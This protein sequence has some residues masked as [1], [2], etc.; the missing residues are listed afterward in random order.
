MARFKDF[1]KVRLTG[2]HVQSA[3]NS[4]LLSNTGC[5]FMQCSQNNPC[6][7]GTCNNGYCCTSSIGTGLTNQP[8]ITP[9]LQHQQSLFTNQFSLPV[10]V[11]VMQPAYNPIALSGCANGGAAVGA[12]INMRCARGYVC[13]MGNIC[14]PSTDYATVTSS[15]AN[16][17]KN[18]FLCT[19]GTQAAGACILG[20]CGSSFSCVNGLCCNVTN[21]TPRCL[22]GSPSVGACLLGQCGAG[23]VCTTG[24]LCCKLTSS[25]FNVVAGTCPNGATSIGA[26]ING[27]CP[28]SY[29]CIN[30][31]CCP[32]DSNGAFRCSNP[33]YALGPCVGNQCPDGG[34]QCDTSTNTCCPA[35]DPVGPCIEPGDQ[36][37]TGHICFKEGATPLCFKECNG[38]GTASGPPLSGE[39]PDGTT[40]IFGV[41][42]TS[43]TRLYD[44][45]SASLISG[46]SSDYYL[47]PI[48][49]GIGSC[50]DGTGAISACI[51][52][53]CGYGYQCYSNI[54]CSPQY[55]NTIIPFSR[56]SLRPIGGQCELT[57]QCMSSMEGLSIC[58][59]G[60]CRCLPGAY[61]HGFTCV[62]RFINNVNEMIADVLLNDAGRTFINGTSSNDSDIITSGS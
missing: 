28:T 21:N 62:S 8:H 6:Y 36:C 60:I 23:F 55:T 50:P 1:A 53:Q 19:D 32:Q 31:Q 35:V 20:Q 13:S 26:C 33:N 3:G 10:P 61:V 27:L 16:P 4:H 42:C 40:L 38:R 15:T 44:S 51:N 22:D 58:E 5:T 49:S 34:Y 37:P 12:C 47:S 48:S 41:C 45:I 57:Q 52:G 2:Y 43:R 9:S 39:C 17:L 25:M 11:N 18:P 59:L 54:C 56:A 46:R 14:C 7:R 29:T 30:G 24:N